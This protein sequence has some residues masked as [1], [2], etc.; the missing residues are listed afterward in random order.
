MSTLESFFSS[1]A[2]TLWG[3][4]LLFAL[5]GLGIF[6]TV[7]TGFVQIRCFPRVFKGFLDGIRNRGG[8]KEAGK[9][10][11]YQALC[12]AIAS[13]VGSGN[14]V[15]VSTAILSG[16]PGALF[17]MWVAALV[18]IATKYAECIKNRFFA[19]KPIAKSHARCYNY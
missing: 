15:G 13:C 5:L 4:W 8:T 16:G 10:S 14:I 1:V 3:D 12:T 2:D 11:S 18:G 6:Y 7:M 19:V 17:W 9:C